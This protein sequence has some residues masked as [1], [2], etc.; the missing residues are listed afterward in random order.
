MTLDGKGVAAMN[1]RASMFANKLYTSKTEFVWFTK[2]GAL[3][4]VGDLL[5]GLSPGNTR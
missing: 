2:E 5:R 4:S 3:E 1:A